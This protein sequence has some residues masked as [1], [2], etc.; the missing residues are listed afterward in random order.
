MINY[1]NIGSTDGNNRNNYVVIMV[2][3]TNSKK[4]Y[5]ETCKKIATK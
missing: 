5:S 2:I 4:L 3:N 1:N